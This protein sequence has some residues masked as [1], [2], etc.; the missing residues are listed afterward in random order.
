MLEIK[1]F[2][3][4]NNQI[5]DVWVKQLDSIHYI[6]VGPKTNLRM[7]VVEI[8]GAGNSSFAVIVE[9]LDNQKA[10]GACLNFDYIFGD[11]NPTFPDVII[12]AQMQITE[13]E[14]QILTVAFK[15]IYKNLQ[16]T[17]KV[18]QAS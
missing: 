17:G 15:E 18:G 13:L 16:V 5:K 2:I 8:P 7:S 10:T 9:N 6:T 14:A 12:Q 4:V 1:S 11:E 3:Q